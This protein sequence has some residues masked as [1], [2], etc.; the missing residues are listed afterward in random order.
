MCAYVYCLRVYVCIFVCVY[1]C[2]CEYVVLIHVCVCAYMYVYVGAYVYVCGCV[3]RTQYFQEI[4]EET[5]NNFLGK[6][7]LN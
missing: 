6:E 2:A 1:V 3:L 7:C 4:T 5:N